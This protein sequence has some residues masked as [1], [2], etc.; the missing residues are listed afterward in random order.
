MREV[1]HCRHHCWCKHLLVTLTLASASAGSAVESVAEDEVMRILILLRNF[2]QGASSVDASGRTVSNLVGAQCLATV[3]MSSKR[4]RAA[5]SAPP[6][7][8]CSGHEQIKKGEWDVCAATADAYDVKNK[9][10][11]HVCLLV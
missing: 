2:I 8:L 10:S 6:R 7:I 1:S 5:C 11:S 4:R 9:A 3:H